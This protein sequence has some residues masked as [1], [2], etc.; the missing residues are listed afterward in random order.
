MSL[1][2]YGDL[3]VSI[4]D[5]IPPGRTPIR[6]R[7]SGPEGMAE[8]LHTLRA[9]LAAGRQ[10]YIVYPLVDESEKLSVK[11]AVAS[12]NRWEKDYLPGCSVGLLHGQMPSEEKELVM[13]RFTNGEY[14]ILVTTSVVEVGVD[15]PNA[16][17]MIIEEAQ[18]FGLAQLHQLRGR[19]GRGKHTGYCFLVA[20]E[21]L[22]AEA[23]ER[24][25]ILEMTSDGFRIAEADLE[26]RGPGEFIGTRQTGAP[27]LQIADLV[28]DSHILEDARKA[29]FELV[30][31]DPNLKNPEHALI[32]A[33]LNERWG[34]KF[35]LVQIG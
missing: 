12:K 32:A 9:E 4:L 2:L 28:R 5:E 1:T 7:V 18:R 17:V 11:S 30:A 8:C 20:G 24:L 21:D 6:T 25:S 15:V 19:V 34:E 29:A 22:S 33:R 35:E 14:Q 31:A 26:M 13:Q 16:T 3:D 23:L 10:A 27:A